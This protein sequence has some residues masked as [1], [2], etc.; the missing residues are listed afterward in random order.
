M[1]TFFLKKRFYYLAERE[2]KR[3]SEQ[4]QAGGVAEGEGEAGS[5]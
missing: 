3:E 5:P 4:V 2:R 1:S